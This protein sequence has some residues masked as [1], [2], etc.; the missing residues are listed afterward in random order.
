[1]RGQRIYVRYK[2]I[3][4][5]NRLFTYVLF[6]FVGVDSVP[7]LAGLHSGESVGQMLESLHTE[8]KKIKFKKF[9]QF[10]SDGIEYDEYVECLDS[11]FEL[12]ENYE[13]N[14]MI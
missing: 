12:R 9:H 4:F 10:I 7:V 1:M 6:A 11:L 2:Q 3:V 14:Y 13:D 8:T 5:L